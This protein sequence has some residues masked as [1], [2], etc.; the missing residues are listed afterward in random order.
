MSI[1]VEWTPNRADPPAILLRRSRREAGKVKRTTLANVSRRPPRL[2]EDIRLL[3][4]GALLV[5]DPA[6]AFTIRRSLPHGP[7]LAVLGV[8]RQLGLRRILHRRPG[9][10]RDLALAAIVAR[11][12]APDSRL[13]TAR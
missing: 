10:A 5:A 1:Y 9:R 7:V 2:I 12:L 6:Q 13:A 8:C 11:V 3:L 4:K